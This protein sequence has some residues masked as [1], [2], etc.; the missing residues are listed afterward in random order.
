MSL[1]SV[2][3]KVRQKAGWWEVWKSTW[4]FSQKVATAKT[5]RDAMAILN[6]IAQADS[7]DLDEV[8]R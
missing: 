2:S 1:F 8:Y 3:Y 7:E 5:K 6:R 4:L